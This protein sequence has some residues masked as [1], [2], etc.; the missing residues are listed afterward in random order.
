MSPD[1]GRG[2]GRLRFVAA[3]LTAAGRYFGA[4][5]N[6]LTKITEHVYWMP[7]GPPDR[8]SL[9]AVVGNRQTLMLDAG[10]SAAHVSAFLVGL[11]AESR[12]RPSAVVYTHSHWDHVLGGAEVGGLVI[13]HALTAGWLVEL[14]ERDWSDEG[15]E[16]RAAAGLSSL[17]HVE[18]VKAE[19]PPP[20]SVEVVPADIVFHDR[21]EVDLGGVTVY[22]H[23]V[24]GDH[25]ADS[26]LMFVEPDAVLFLGD[27]MY[28]SPEGALTAE[29]AF[30]LRDVI[31]GFDAAHHVEGHHESVS[32]QTE[33]E[34]LFEK[35]QLAEEAIREGSAIPAPDED[36]QYFV[37][38]FSAGRAPAQ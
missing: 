25:S 20:R 36:T 27:C 14:A 7:P 35:M 31:L 19:L 18:A 23:H 22:V 29:S 24:G 15:L 3:T 11:L 30:R 26:S 9:C 6:A 32:S 10:S 21:I 16:R 38:S 28:P 17:E 8:P 4:A 2:G 37:R 34:S 1:L 12:V 5:M 13:A 33:M